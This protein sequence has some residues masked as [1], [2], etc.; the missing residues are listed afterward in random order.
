MTA[1]LM[2]GQSQAPLAG[3]TLDPEGRRLL[4]RC[5]RGMKELDVLLDR[6]ARVQLPGASSEQRRTFAVFLELPDPV[7]ADYLFGYAIPPEPELAEL[8]RRIADTPCLPDAPGR[9]SPPRPPHMAIPSPVRHDSA[10]KRL[11]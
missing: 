11:T 2:R 8:A 3:A 7:L 4:W 1:E 10:P 6:F 5:R 9:L